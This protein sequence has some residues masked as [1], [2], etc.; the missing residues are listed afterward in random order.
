MGASLTGRKFSTFPGDLVTEVT[1]NREVKIRGGLMRGGYS[2]SVE[3][4]D[5][6]ILNTHALAKLRRALKYRINVKTSSN[7]K[8]FSH[9]QKKMHEQYFQQLLKSIP[10]GPSHGPARNIMSGVEI[11][12]KIIDGLLAAKETGVEL[13]LEFVKN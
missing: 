6:F 8:E 12:S 2:T 3:T 10:T 1:V 5:D 7:H 11:S 9:G 4:V 13:H